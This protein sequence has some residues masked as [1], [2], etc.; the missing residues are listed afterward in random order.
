M[1]TINESDF[2]KLLASEQQDHIDL[3]I[4]ITKYTKIDLSKIS[5]INKFNTKLSKA[6]ITI[7]VMV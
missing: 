4:E 5:Q 2:F 6:T 3:I 7:T 1:Q